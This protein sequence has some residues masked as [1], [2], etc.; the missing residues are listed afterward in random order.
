MMAVHAL[1]R[2]E[3]RLVQRLAQKESADAHRLVVSLLSAAMDDWSWLHQ[4]NEVQDML[5]HV[6]QCVYVPSILN[7]HG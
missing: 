4:T 3:P 2:V 6:H 7:Q 1:L 5:L